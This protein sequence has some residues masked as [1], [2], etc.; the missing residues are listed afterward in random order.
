[1]A[2]AAG[3]SCVQAIRGT[4]ERILALCRRTQMAR[5]NELPDG[6]FNIAAKYPPDPRLP[7]GPVA[8]NSQR[9]RPLGSCMRPCVGN[10]RVRYSGLFTRN[11]QG[12]RADDAGVVLCDW[13]TELLAVVAGVLCRD[14]P[15]FSQFEV[16]RLVCRV[17]SFEPVASGAFAS[18]IVPGL[19][20][21]GVACQQTM[22]SS[23]LPT[24]HATEKELS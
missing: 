15:Y 23:A 14:Y 1:M 2:E 12:A 21:H 4:D 8:L 20:I 19:A 11:L 3:T 5:R 17:A 10:P 9:V 18:F 6:F 16:A 7:P 24:L 13:K 22:N